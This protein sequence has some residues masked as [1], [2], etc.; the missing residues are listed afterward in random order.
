M[1]GLECPHCGSELEHDDVFG[2]LAG[3]GPY[4]VKGDIYRCP[5]GREESEECDSSTFHVAGS[6]YAYRKGDTSLQEGY[7]C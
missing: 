6:F 7:P 3:F 4:E 1:S 2:K 5:K